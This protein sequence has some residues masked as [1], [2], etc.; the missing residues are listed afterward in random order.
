MTATTHLTR[1]VS[2]LLVTAVSFSCPARAADGLESECQSEASLY[3]IPQ[4]QRADY[5]AGCIASRGGYAVIEPAEQTSTEEYAQG[6][7]LPAVET[8]A[9]E[10]S[11]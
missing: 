9:E 10:F 5:V 6:T 8:A 2:C 11:Q 1:A 3:E 7:E 4:E